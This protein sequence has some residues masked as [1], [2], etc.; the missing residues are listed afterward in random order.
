MNRR[1]KVTCEHLKDAWDKRKAPKQNLI[2]MGLSADPNE[3]VKL[4][5]NLPLLMRSEQATKPNPLV[6]NKKSV[7]EKME[8]DA[9]APRVKNFQLPKTQVLELTK[10]MDKYGEDYKSMA[11]DR[12]L[13]YMQQTWKQI[14]QRINR[15]KSIPEQYNEYLMRKEEEKKQSELSSGTQDN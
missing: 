1:P 8:T 14:R 15:F 12:K 7:V 2:E 10:F 6:P 13:N 9:K 11:K 3:A 4:P 5:S